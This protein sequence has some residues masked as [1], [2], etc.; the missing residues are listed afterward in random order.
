MSR[1][2]WPLH[3]RRLIV[4]ETRQDTAKLREELSEQVEEFLA[5]GNKITEVPIGTSGLKPVV[6]THKN[7]NLKL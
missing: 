6:F 3:L 2:Y 7:R 5:K 1:P 4:L